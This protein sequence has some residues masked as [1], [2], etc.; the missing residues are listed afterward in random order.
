[1]IVVIWNVI[2][3]CKSSLIRPRPLHP[4]FSPSCYIKHSAVHN[5]SC[6]QHHSVCHTPIKKCAFPL[7]QPVVQLSTCMHTTARSHKTAHILYLSQFGVYGDLYRPSIVTPRQQC[8]LSMSVGQDGSWLQ[9]AKNFLL[10]LPRIESG[11]SVWMPSPDG[12]CSV[13][14][15]SQPVSVKEQNVFLLRN[16]SFMID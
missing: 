13:F 16:R 4:L 9:V 3:K 15:D 1:M 10:S 12:L 8:P 5:T 6:C 14:V 11:L 7:H 2:S